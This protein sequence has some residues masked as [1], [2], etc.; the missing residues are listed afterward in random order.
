MDASSDLW[1]AESIFYPPAIRET[2]P[3]SSEAV[4]NPEEAN[5]AQSEVVQIIVPSSESSDGGEPPDTAR[6]PEDLN[7]EA[8][9]E[10]VEPTTSA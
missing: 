10:D 1:K 6:A 7:F 2:A 8:P 5:A 9:K 3:P 4:R